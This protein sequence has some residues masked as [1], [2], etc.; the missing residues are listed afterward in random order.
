LF[1]FAQRRE[2][3]ENLRELMDEVRKLDSDFE[4]QRIKIQDTAQEVNR[5]LQEYNKMY[6]DKKPA[7]YKTGDLVL[8][9]K[10]QSK[11]GENTKLLPKYKGPYQIKVVLNK[12]RYVITDLPGYLTNKLYNTILSADKIKP[13]IKVKERR[14]EWE[15]N[16]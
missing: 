14:N 9:R 10:L 3:D 5:Q 11:P 13:W 12:N 8:V 6:Y 7:Q 2:E 4:Q 15:R 16:Q 1:S